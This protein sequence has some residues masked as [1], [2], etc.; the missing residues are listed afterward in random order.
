[1]SFEKL[2]FLEALPLREYGQVVAPVLASMTLRSLQSRPDA[3]DGAKEILIKLHRGTNWDWDRWDS[4]SRAQAIDRLRK[5]VEVGEVVLVAHTARAALTPAFIKVDGHW[6]ITRDGKQGYAHRRFLYQLQHMERKEKEL[7]TLRTRNRPL[8]EEVMEPAA[9]PGFR[10]PTLGPHEGLHNQDWNTVKVKDD[11]FK[12]VRKVDMENLSAEDAIA[13]KALK[14]QGWDNK[15]VKQILKSG[16]SFTP[17][18]LKPGDKLHAFGTQ[19][20]AT[21]TQNSAYWLDEP[22]FKDVQSKFYKNGQ[23]D[24]EGVKNHLAL[25]C[26]NRASDITTVKITQAT[27]G[28]EAQIVKAR[29]LVQYTDKSGYTTGMVGKIMPGGGKQITV[30]PAHVAKI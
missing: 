5:A 30:N 10:K 13:R 18:E 21:N 6:Q 17:K 3:I 1:M 26:F 28:I 7:E 12:T 9:G 20:R 16:D 4:H 27:T 22:G 29:E 23:W 25:P 24:K 8:R 11:S 14:E 2:V 15:K 19:G